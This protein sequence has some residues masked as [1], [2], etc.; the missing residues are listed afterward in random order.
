[1]TI[2]KMKD[3]IENVD[4]DHGWKLDHT[5][6][7]S[8]RQFWFYNFPTGATVIAEKEAYW[9]PPMPFRNETGIVH[10]DTFHFYFFREGDGTDTKPLSYYRQTK[11]SVLN[12]LKEA[13]RKRA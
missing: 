9:K 11:T 10:W 5:D 2:K 4:R 12:L 3:I 6:G 7:Y 8:G 1:M 13:E